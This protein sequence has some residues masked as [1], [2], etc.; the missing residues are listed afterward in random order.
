[1]NAA[2]R[3]GMK[4]GKKLAGGFTTNPNQAFRAGS[5][6]YLRR[7]GKR[8][9]LEAAIAARQDFEAGARAGYMEIIGKEFAQ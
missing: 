3:A 8:Y 6:D 1:M 2:H 7:H 5:A 9:G 4:Y